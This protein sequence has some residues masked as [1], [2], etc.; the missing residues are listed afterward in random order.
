M[1]D[2]VTYSN[3]NFR[4]SMENFINNNNFSSTLELIRIDKLSKFQQKVSA[5]VW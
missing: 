4:N 5:H 3:E 1:N 2:G